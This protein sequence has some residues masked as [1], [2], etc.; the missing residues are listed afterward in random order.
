M[1]NPGRSCAT[2]RFRCNQVFRGTATGRGRVVHLDARVAERLVAHA[3]RA[4]EAAERVEQPAQRGQAV[5]EPRRA[6]ARHGAPRR[7]RFLR[8]GCMPQ[9]RTGARGCRE[10]TNS[11][12]TP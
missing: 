2:Q 7:G 11:S 6:H 9:P 1:R 10:T 12:H 3:V 8:T 5:A 4:V